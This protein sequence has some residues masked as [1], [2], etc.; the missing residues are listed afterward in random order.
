MRK[1][2]ELVRDSLFEADVA[3]I[4]GS[5]KNA[6]DFLEAVELV[7]A[8]EPECGTHLEKSHVWFLPAHTIPL[9]VYYAFCDEKGVLDLGSGD[10]DFGSMKPE[11]RK[12]EETGWDRLDRA[13]RT[14]LTVPK[15]RLV[16][17]EARIKAQ[18]KRKRAKR[19]G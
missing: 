4:C 18:R 3:A 11:P 12:N 2:R 15:E 13:F 5:I 19:R 17:E 16:K 1:M 14:V 10:R 9:V 6:D 7:L 8:R